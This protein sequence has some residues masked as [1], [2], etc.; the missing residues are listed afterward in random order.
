MLTG[1]GMVGMCCMRRMGVCSGSGD[2]WQ[3]SFMMMVGFVGMMIHDNA[4]L[5]LITPPQTGWGIIQDYT[6]TS[7]PGAYAIWR[8]PGTPSN[9]QEPAPRNMEP[10]PV[11]EQREKAVLLFDFGHRHKLTVPVMQPDRPRAAI[12]AQH[13]H[14]L[15]IFQDVQRIIAVEGFGLLSH[16]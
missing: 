2:R 10:A 6:G 3:V 11:A 8:I 15:P 7:C 9:A 1:L 5:G 16:R 4:S 14:D 12:D 13:P